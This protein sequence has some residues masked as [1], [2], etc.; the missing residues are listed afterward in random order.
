MLRKQREGTS[1][2]LGGEEKSW[3]PIPR[4]A[5]LHEM[6]DPLHDVEE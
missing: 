1:I 2:T 4:G 5:K 6:R 3:G